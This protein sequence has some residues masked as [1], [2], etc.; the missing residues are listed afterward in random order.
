MPISFDNPAAVPAPGGHY[1]HVA[2]VETRA[3]TWLQL[4]GQVALD[5]AGAVVGDSLR[6]QAEFVH[7]VIR[8]VLAA[9]GATYADVVNV[10]TYLTDI[11]EMPALREVRAAYFTG[12]APSSTVVE[13]SALIRPELRIEVEVQAYLD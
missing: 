6:E 3:G 8:E 2:R 5:A 7:G 10:R 13:V 1:S 9:H 11:R 12:P 4:S